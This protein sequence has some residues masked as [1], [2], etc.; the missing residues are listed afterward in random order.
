M[1]HRKVSTSAVDWAIWMPVIP[2][3]MGIISTTGM[4]NRP[5]RATD[6]K[7]ADTV[8]PMDCC[9]MLLITIQPW[10]IKVAHWNRRATE[11]MAMASVAAGAD[12]LMIEVHNDPA[13]ALC[14]GAQSL[15]PEDFSH[16]AGKI[17]KVREII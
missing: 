16:L 11:P 3:N 12:G 4:K 14:D 6:R 2:R 10:V 17:Q 15:T 13:H 8:L 7:V 5:C 9:I 1:A